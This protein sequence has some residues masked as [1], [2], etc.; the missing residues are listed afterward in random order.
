M[1]KTAERRRKGKMKHKS[2]V[3]AFEKEG[4]A[5]RKN[6]LGYGF[7]CSNGKNIATW[8]L[9]GGDPERNISAVQVMKTDERNDSTTDYFPGMFCTQVKQIIKNMYYE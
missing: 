2:I 5:V 4:W 9:N 1:N 3:K 8:F 6:E 7:F